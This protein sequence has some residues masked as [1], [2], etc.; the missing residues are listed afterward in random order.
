MPPRLCGRQIIIDNLQGAR[1]DLGRHANGLTRRMLLAS[2]SIKGDAAAQI[3]A[4]LFAHAAIGFGLDDRV[5][6][7]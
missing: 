5:G 3:E 6:A 1:G 2:E 4:S 7:Y